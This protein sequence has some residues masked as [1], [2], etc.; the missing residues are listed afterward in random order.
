[1]IGKLILALLN[2]IGKIVSIIL[3][4]VDLL[5]SSMLP[6]ISSVLVS[7]TEYLSMPGRFMSWIFSLVHIPNIVPTLIIAYWVFKYG[8]TT[9]IAGTKKVITL[10]RR[11]KM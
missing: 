5:V 1:M 6:N 2:L 3:A 8:I 10:Y 9:A 7:I 4:P 11:F